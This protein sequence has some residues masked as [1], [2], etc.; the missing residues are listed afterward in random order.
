MT[1]FVF[2]EIEFGV[3]GNIWNGSVLDNELQNTYM[4]WIL[5]Q[6]YIE[7]VFVPYLVRVRF[8]LPGC[9][10]VCVL[11]CHRSFFPEDRMSLRY[12]KVGS[13]PDVRTLGYS[14]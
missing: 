1:C 8:Y 11:V 6:Q 5:G 12:V 10:L 7:V 9:V 2:D 4:H 14:K 13:C 3:H